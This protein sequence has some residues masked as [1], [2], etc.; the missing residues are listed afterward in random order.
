MHKINQNSMSGHLTMRKQNCIM[1]DKAIDNQVP[2]PISFRPFDEFFLRHRPQVQLF[3]LRGAETVTLVGEQGTRLTFPAY[4]FATPA[5]QPVGGELQLR[6]TEI[7]HARQALLAAQPTTSED[8]LVDAYV[9]FHLAVFKDGMA[10]QLVQPV[11][12]ALPL[13]EGEAKLGM[14]LFSRS[15]P[16]VQSVRSEHLFDW[17]LSADRVRIGKLNK[18]RYYQF[19]LQRLGWHQCGSFYLDQSP[20]AMLSAQLVTEAEDFEAKAAFLLFDG[21]TGLARMHCGNRGFTAINVPAR[22]S[23]HIV[24]F[25]QSKER[26]YFGCRQLQKI[27]SKRIDVFLSPSSAEGILLALQGILR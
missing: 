15:I 23:G 12:V 17:R 3:S 9:Q 27:G 24:V 10:L 7:T 2:K 8:R 21:I 13:R 20:K 19:S 26:L 18:R 5:G 4:A 25:G 16:T 1:L 6:L 22:A 11:Q 14:Q